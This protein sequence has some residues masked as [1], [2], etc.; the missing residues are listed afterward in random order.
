MVRW[1]RDRV[2][3]VVLTPASA[4]VDNLPAPRCKECGTPGSVH[5]V[6][7]WHDGVGSAVPFTKHWKM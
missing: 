2:D 5:I 1:P 6:P 3:L 7:N 4:L